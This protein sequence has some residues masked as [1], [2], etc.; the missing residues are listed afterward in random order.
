MQQKVLNTIT[1]KNME[2]KQTA[3]DRL[4][5]VLIDRGFIDSTYALPESALWDVVK[6]SKQ[7]EKEQINSAF[8]D[9]YYIESLY[10]ARQYYDDTYG[11]KGS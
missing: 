2:T 8:Y 5:Q 4:V 9:G 6:Q 7:M 10:D 3:V 1:M 11:P